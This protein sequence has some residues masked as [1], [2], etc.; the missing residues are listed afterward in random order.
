MFLK[1]W[2]WGTSKPTP[3]CTSAPPWSLSVWVVKVIKNPIYFQ[4]LTEQGSSRSRWPGKSGEWPSLSLLLHSH[5]HFTARSFLASCC[6][7]RLPFSQGKGSACCA[8]WP[9]PPLSLAPPWS[10]RTLCAQVSMVTCGTGCQRCQTRMHKPLGGMKCARGCPWPQ[11]RPF[12]EC[13]SQQLPAQGPS[14]GWVPSDPAAHHAWALLPH[15]L[16]LDFL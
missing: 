16:T 15:R 3:Y 8:C 13:A 9:L 7:C 10:P 14:G 1:H 4:Y 11:K 6:P 12:P 2:G 5:T